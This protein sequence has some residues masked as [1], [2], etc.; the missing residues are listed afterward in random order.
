MTPEH[1]RAAAI[2]QTLEFACAPDTKLLAKDTMGYRRARYLIKKTGM[3][4][5]SLLAHLKE[6]HIAWLASNK[7]AEMDV[8]EYLVTALLD[9]AMAEDAE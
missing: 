7:P 5:G 8:N 6:P 3:N 1:A 4:V 9:D 2:K